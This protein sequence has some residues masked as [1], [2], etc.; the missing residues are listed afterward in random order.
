MAHRP[1]VAIALAV[2]LVT[3]TAAFAGTVLVP[4]WRAEAAVGDQMLPNLQALPAR[5]ISIAVD[6]AGAPQLRFSTISWNAGTG[7]LT[8]VAGSTDSTTNSQD[9]WQWIKLEGGGE[10]KRL[11]GSFVW[12]PLHNHFHFEGYAVY[13]LQPAA[14]TGASGR[15]SQKTTF[16]V[17]DTNRIDGTLAGSP[18]SGFYTT[19]GS[20]TQGMSVGW[21]D[22]YGSTLAGQ[23][24]DLTGLAD[25][26]Y[27]LFVDVDPQ[28]R[29]TEAS[30]ADNRSCVLLRIG[31]AARTVQVLNANSCDAPVAPT[32]ASISPTQARI[33][34][35]VAVTITGTG[36]TSGIAV[37]FANGNGPAPSLR[38]VVVVSDTTITATLTIGRKKAGA[39]PVWD[40][41]VG[42]ATLPN[43]CTVT[44]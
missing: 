29:L 14:A 38:N 40:L 15:T 10:A 28:N 35:S 27:K 7:P 4:T 30:E 31:V 42:S 39:D 41:S 43:A 34:T 25:G 6:A 21:G 5:E 8:L 26:D 3:V 19:C 12:H 9:V 44:P 1:R 24:I 11:A 17:M 33:G 22:R 16:C 37:S 23:S 20:S 32:L 36:F 13:T 2:G 18:T